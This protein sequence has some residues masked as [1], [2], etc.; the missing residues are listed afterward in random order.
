M[1]VQHFDPTPPETFGEASGALFF[2][3]TPSLDRRSALSQAER[4]RTRLNAD[5][6]ARVKCGTPYTSNSSF[7]LA[8]INE[9]SDR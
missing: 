8:T 1:R 5:Q 3:I 9:F 7:Q 2:N 4:R 6:N